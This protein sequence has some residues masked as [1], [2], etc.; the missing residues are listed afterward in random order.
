MNVCNIESFFFFL[1]TH[2]IGK[3]NVIIYIYIYI[4]I[5]IFHV[6]YPIVIIF[7]LEKC[8]LIIVTFLYY[9][10]VLMANTGSS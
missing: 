8:C 5:Y 7:G 9:C 10:C 2:V 6:L 4:Y 3:V 1:E